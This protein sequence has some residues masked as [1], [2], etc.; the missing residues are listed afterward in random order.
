MRRREFIKKTATGSLLSGIGLDQLSHSRKAYAARQRSDEEKPLVTIAASDESNLRNPAPLDV[1]LTYDQVRDIVWLAL[2]RDTSSRSLLNIVKKDNW[3]VIKTNIVRIV[4]LSPEGYYGR[5][6][7]APNFERDGDALALVTDLRVVKAVAEYLIEKITPRRITIAEGPAEWYNSKGKI[8]PGNYIDGW[9]YEFKGFDNLSYVKIAEQLNGKNNSVVDIIDLNEDEGVYVTD[10]D[11]Y[12]T[13]IG[14]LQFTPPG[15]RD[16]TS[17]KEP[18][19]RK[20]VFMPKTVLEKDILITVPVLKTHGS[21]GTTLFMKNFIGCVHSPS[22]D[23]KVTHKGVFHKGSDLNLVRGI[24]DL[25]CAINPDYGVAEGFWAVMNHHSG[26]MGVG[27]NHNV[28]IAGGDIVAAE[29]VANMVMGFNPLDFD[30]LRL[31]H[32]KKLGEWN[33]NRISITGPPVKSIRVNYAR[34][35]NKYVARG[36][37]KWQ[38]LGPLQNP[39]ERAGELK[40]K[41]G[42]LLAGNEWK[43]LDGDALIDNEPLLGRARYQEC[44]LYPI[45]GSDEAQEN[46]LYY[47]ALIING[48]R[49]GLVGQLLVGIDGG[50]FMVFLNGRRRSYPATPLTYDPTP[51]PFITLL[52]G[53]NTLV[54]EVKKTNEKN[55]PVKIAVNICDLDG[56][57]LEDITFN[58]AGE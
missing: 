7:L 56:D 24:V 51:S 20:G 40:P 16:G 27:F 29:A 44:L 22:Y 19:R 13:G 54:L 18:T 32:M 12:N 42:D 31:A 11:P 34:A 37:R 52:E 17:D 46:S 33:P 45:P 14:A 49:K 36:I 9:H 35:S 25:T 39:L 8:K 10:F 2:D 6:G 28:V 1:E 21:V 43:L 38:M 57:R 58:P 15:D 3:V 30:I 50:D 53:E 4:W 41:L 55:Q 48:M 47:L 23:P 26:Q 5:P